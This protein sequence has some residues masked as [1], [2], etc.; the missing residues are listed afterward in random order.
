MKWEKFIPWLERHDIEVFL[1]MFSFLTM[2][3]PVT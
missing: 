3:T 2:L 1:L